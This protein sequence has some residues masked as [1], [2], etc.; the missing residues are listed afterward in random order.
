MTS[1]DRMNSSK[2][3]K[4]VLS[5]IRTMESEKRTHLSELRTGIGVMTIPLSLLTILIAF[6]EQYSVEEV[7]GLITA[8]IVGV[9]LLLVIGGYLVV[10]AFRKL[11]RI[12]RL[13]N[14]TI[15]DTSHMLGQY[16][17]DE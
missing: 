6:S 17:D 2:D 1:E 10:R 11:R 16:F 14:S 12:E 3:L 13:R 5:I 8:L 15:P 9:I 7:L 4:V